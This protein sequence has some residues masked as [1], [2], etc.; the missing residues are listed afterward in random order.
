MQ[1]DT[2]IWL[3]RESWCR[4]PHC[5]VTGVLPSCLVRSS[6]AATMASRRISSRLSITPGVSLLSHHASCGSVNSTET[7]CIHLEPPSAFMSPS[8]LSKVSCRTLLHTALK[9]AAAADDGDFPLG[10]V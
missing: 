5:Q 8:S 7:A 6:L 3:V 1:I 9:Y 4:R 10:W 2:R